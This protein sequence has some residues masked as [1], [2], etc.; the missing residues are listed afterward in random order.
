MKTKVITLN[1]AKDRQENIK[2]YFKKKEINF[3]F[4]S[5]VIADEI[6]FY[7]SKDPYFVFNKKNIKL[8]EKNLLKYTSRLW[9]RFGEVAALMAHYK[10]WKELL[11]DNTEFMYLICEDDCM[12]S[13]TFN[14]SSLD[15]FNYD[16]IDLL[17]LQAITAHH[18]DKK[19]LVDELPYF[20]NNFNLK[21]INNYKNYICEGMVA[22]CITKKGAKKLCDYIETNGY[23]GPVDNL[24]VRLEGF[25]CVCP[26]NLSDYF[27]LDNTSTYSYT[28]DGNFIHNYPINNLELQSKNILQLITL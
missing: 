6:V 16:E 23:D 7:N 20:N 21:L 10:I 27:Y 28:H 14:I 22:Y 13:K 11:E 26:A 3:D 25:E 18:E 5:G 1:D 17:Y 19:M 4:V 12:P 8:N 15:T 9:F 2:K 24:I